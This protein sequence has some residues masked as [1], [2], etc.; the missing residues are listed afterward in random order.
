MSPYLLIIAAA[1][2]VAACTPQEVGLVAESAAGVATVTGHPGAAYL[3]QC[4]G[5]AFCAAGGPH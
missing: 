5:E 4:F 2:A 3:I 1:L